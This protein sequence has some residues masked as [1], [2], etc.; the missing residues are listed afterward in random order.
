ML[1]LPKNIA[2]HPNVKAIEA[3]FR[4]NSRL[5]RP[6]G[7]MRVPVWVFNDTLRLALKGTYDGK[8]LIQGLES[9]GEHLDME[10]KGLKALKKLPGQTQNERLSRLVILSNDGSER[11]YHN[12]ES[13]LNRHASRAMAVIVNATAEEL[14]DAFTKKANPAKALLIDERK[15]LETFLAAL[16]VTR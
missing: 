5:L 8:H 2:S 1:K 13:I 15:A 11:F 4:T 12:A 16:V 14:G 7:E 6:D 3:L 9:I 10:L